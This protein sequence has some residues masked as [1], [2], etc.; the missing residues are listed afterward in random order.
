MCFDYALY[1]LSY[2]NLIMLGAVLP[3]YN[4]GKEKERGNSAGGDEDE[5]RADDPRNNEKV[6]QMIDSFK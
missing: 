6:M 4:G 3:S 5:L 1:D 2:S